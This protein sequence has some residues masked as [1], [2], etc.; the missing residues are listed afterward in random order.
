MKLSDN[1]PIED[2]FNVVVGDEMS[3]Y[4]EY[5]IVD[6]VVMDY[7]ILRLMELSIGIKFKKFNKFLVCFLGCCF[8]LF[9]PMIFDYKLIL[10]LYRIATSIIMVLCI[11]KYKNLKN[12]VVY[13]LIFFAYTFF[14]GGVCLGVIQMLGIE[15]T[16]TSLVMYSFKFPLGLFGVILIVVL[17]IMGNVIKVIKSKIHSSNYI[18]KISL[19]NGKN[20]FS[21]YAF[22]DSGNKVK[23][24]GEVVNIISI[25]AFLRLYNELS[26]EDVI[27]GKFE[28][29]NIRGL[30][31]I[32]IA[33][34]GGAKKYLSF[35]VDNVDI[36][37]KKYSLTR[38]ALSWKNFGE[39]DV[40]LNSEYEGG[41]YEK[42]NTKS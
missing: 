33:G 34:L 24:R 9:M 37:G 39:Y 36:D 6:N 25:D 11:K 22:L 14:V 20:V 41:C 12:I 28:H 13:Y 17:K 16:M 27:L 10:F 29:E 8:A 1:V 40:I 30:E 42:I 3:I 26:L 4:I 32:D 2:N 5:V 31:Y 38:F 21:G 19:V 23:H 18:K 7:I 35:I 15:Y